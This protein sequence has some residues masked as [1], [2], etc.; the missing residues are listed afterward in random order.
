VYYDYK[1]SYNPIKLSNDLF[2][3]II[4]PKDRSNLTLY[5]DIY[6]DYIIAQAPKF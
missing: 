3:I 1:G 2:K 6:K 5:L 4:Q